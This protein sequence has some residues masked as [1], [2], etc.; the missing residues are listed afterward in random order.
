M[1]MW[2]EMS[3]IIWWIIQTITFVVLITMFWQIF[4]SVKFGKF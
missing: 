3:L 4:S 1:L 2:S